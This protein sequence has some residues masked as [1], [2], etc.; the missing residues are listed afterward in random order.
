MDIKQIIF[1]DKLFDI[2]KE[3]HIVNYLKW[4]WIY[5]SNNGKFL[6]K[7][8]CRNI[9]MITQHSWNNCADH[10]ETSTFKYKCMN[11]MINNKFYQNTRKIG[12]FIT[13][14]NRINEISI[15]ILK[16]LPLFSNDDLVFNVLITIKRQCPG[17]A[18]HYPH[19]LHFGN[20]YYTPLGGIHKTWFEVFAITKHECLPRSHTGNTENL[21]HRFWM[22]IM[23]R[24]LGLHTFRMSCHI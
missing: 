2:Q 9:K 7:M 14:K 16:I 23:A 20:L 15:R 3:A 4:W 13:T 12:W 18:P 22:R 11:S 21:L 6:L 24:V 5:I 1:C 17:W 8:I 10:N 19:F